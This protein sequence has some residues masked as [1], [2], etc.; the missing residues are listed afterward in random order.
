MAEVFIVKASG[1]Q[2]VFDPT[3]LRDSLTRAGAGED[4]INRILEH[5]EG[6]VETGMTT[7]HIY[8]HAFNLLKKEE[9]KPVAARYSL[10]RALAG[11]G[12]SGF[13]FEQ[14]LGELFRG[15]GYTVETRVTL[16]GKCAEH[17]VDV[18]AYKNDELIVSEAK[19]HNKSGFKTDM[20]TA[21]YVSA[22]A[23]DL[24]DTNFDN[25]RKHGQTAT[26]WL[27][28][29]TKFT[30]NAVKY[31][32]CAGL[33]RL[34]GWN[35]PHGETLQDIIE[36][37]GL[38]PISCL[39]TLSTKNKQELMARGYV[40]CRDIRTDESRLEA[41]GLSATQRNKVLE[42]VRLLCRPVDRPH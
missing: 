11:L 6:E 14:F 12:P 5:I 19:F 15:K 16:A 20:K 31:A 40:L 29:N 36:E 33:L 26:F 10:R 8:R 34:V 9:E 2:E 28:T 38:H 27:I 18:I 37:V 41:V 32:T 4:T 21:L 1:E 22:R 23:R 13:P 42:E 35:Y 25:R 17:E 3:K 24:Q 30:R 39:T 7:T